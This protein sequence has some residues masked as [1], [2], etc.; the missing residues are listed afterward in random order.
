MAVGLPYNGRAMTGDLPTRIG[1][2]LIICTAKSFHVYAVGRV[3]VDGQE[4]FHGEHDVQYIVDRGAAVAVAKAIQ[5]TGH[6]TFL[7][8][9]DKGEWREISQ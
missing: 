9:L 2:V 6:R 7:L 4:S 3:S 8:D 5:S 1:D